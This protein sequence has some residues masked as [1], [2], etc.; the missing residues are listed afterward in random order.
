MKMSDLEIYTGLGCCK[1]NKCDDCPYK[2]YITYGCKGLL[3]KDA[4]HSI[5]RLMRELEDARFQ[6]KNGWG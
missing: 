3:I 5:G 6:S 2:K 4:E 1:Q